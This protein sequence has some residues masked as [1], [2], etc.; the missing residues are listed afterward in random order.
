MQAIR[1]VVKS[2]PRDFHM[3]LPDWAVGQEVEV[4]VLPREPHSKPA[5][6]R[7]RRP[8]ASLA[9]TRIVGDIVSPIVPNSDLEIL[10]ETSS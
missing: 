8:A 6:G 1:E 5:S 10:N 7:K 3:T 4:I 9:G 2:A